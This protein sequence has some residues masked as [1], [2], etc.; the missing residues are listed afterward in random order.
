MNQLNKIIETTKETVKKSSSYRPISSLEEDFEK[1]D[2]ELNP[3]DDHFQDAKEVFESY[4]TDPEYREIVDEGRFVELNVGKC[5]ELKLGTKQTDIYKPYGNKWTSSSW[6][7][8][9]KIYLHF[10]QTIRKP[11]FAKCKMHRQ[12]FN[13]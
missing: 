2:E 9:F 1:L 8:L 7:I 12:K 5:T 13:L 6:C 3:S 4:V 11:C 10:V